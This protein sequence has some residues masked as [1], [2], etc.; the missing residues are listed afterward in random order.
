MEKAVIMKRISCLFILA[1]IGVTCMAQ[2][3]RFIIKINTPRLQTADPALFNNL[4]NQVTEFVNNRRWTN[5]SYQEYERIQ[6][7]MNL[8][9]TEELS[10]TS[11]RAD[12]DIQAIRPVFGTSYE[13]TLLNHSD[14]EV[15]FEFDESR[16][17]N[18]SSNLYT[19]NLS[20]IL[21]FYLYYIKTKTLRS[22][23]IW[24]HSKLT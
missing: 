22:T 14:K 20:S 9:I 19:D 8:T 10:S 5:D 13:S 16:P 23:I 24:V 6:G 17:I 15:L 21:A 3:F 11:F 4:E 7:N 2:E 18:Y 1:T 12:L